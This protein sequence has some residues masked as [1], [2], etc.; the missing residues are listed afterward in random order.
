MAYNSLM[1]GLKVDRKSGA[2]VLV[3][4]V[5]SFGISVTA[6]RFPLA[7]QAEHNQVC[8]VVGV[9]NLDGTT[10]TYWPF[11]SL[12]VG[13]ELTVT[14]VESDSFD[15]PTTIDFGDIEPSVDV[16]EETKRR[17]RECA[18]AWGWKLKENP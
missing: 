2:P 13:E 5:P 14:V 16:S 11:D 12:P 9:N 18:A 10:L 1:L 6:G 7:I 15:P 17:V 3:G 4:G 8:K